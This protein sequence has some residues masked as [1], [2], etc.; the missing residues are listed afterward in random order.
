MINRHRG[1]GWESLHLAVDDASAFTEILPDERKARAVAFLERAL[2][3]FARYGIIVARIRT[4]H[5][6]AC[7]GHDFRNACARGRAAPAHQALHAAPQRQRPSGSSTR[8]CAKCDYSHALRSSQ[9]RA[10]LPRWLHLDHV[11]RP[12]TALTGPPISRL[13]NLRS[14]HT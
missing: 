7:R 10:A 8:S 13:A 3:W 6:N 12:H 4:D 1:I 9:E 2:A 11:R 5:G 14:N